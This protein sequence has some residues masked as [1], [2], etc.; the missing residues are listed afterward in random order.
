MATATIFKPLVIR[1]IRENKGNLF[2]LPADISKEELIKWTRRLKADELFIKC[3]DDSL[4]GLASPRIAGMAADCCDKW[5]AVR[6]SSFLADWDKQGNAVSFSLVKNVVSNV[7]FW[8]R[9]NVMDGFAFRPWIDEHFPALPPTLHNGAIKF[10]PVFWAI[11]DVHRQENHG[12]PETQYLKTFE[13][14]LFDSRFVFEAARFMYC[15]Q[16]IEHAA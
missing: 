16:F 5:L 14:H 8:L 13:K 2:A 12:I 10:N 1:L 4:S 11:F 15:R 9:E 6:M 7:A 3:E